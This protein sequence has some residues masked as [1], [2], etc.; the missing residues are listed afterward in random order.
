[1]IWALSVAAMALR[2]GA[3]GLWLI[4]TP[5]MLDN[6]LK[7]NSDRLCTENPVSRCTSGLGFETVLQ[8]GNGAFRVSR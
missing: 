7:C 8:V 4:K 2:F 1:M 3:L 6:F 5:R